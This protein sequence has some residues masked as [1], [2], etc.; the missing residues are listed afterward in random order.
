MLTL[1][2]C[3]DGR[4]PRHS[5][6]RLRCGAEVTPLDDSSRRAEPQRAQ[7]SQSRT[8][9]RPSLADDVSHVSCVPLAA[10]FGRQCS[11]LI[12]PW[13]LGPGATNPTPHGWGWVRRS[14]VLRSPMRQRGNSSR[15]MRS[16]KRTPGLFRLI[17]DR[18]TVSRRWLR[19]RTNRPLTQAARQE[20]VKHPAPSRG[21]Q[22]SGSSIM[23]H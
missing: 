3:G 1:S 17:G 2:R 15:L 21:R 19:G 9:A 22:S 5:A 8:S 10:G 13:P 4:W 18:T 11:A 6:N 23:C 7:R 14:S 20:S 16:K 12:S